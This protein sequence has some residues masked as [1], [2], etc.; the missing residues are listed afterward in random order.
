MPLESK[1]VENGKI[2]KTQDM[3]QIAVGLK[4]KLLLCCSRSHSFVVNQT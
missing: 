3:I 2:R 1:L 4:V